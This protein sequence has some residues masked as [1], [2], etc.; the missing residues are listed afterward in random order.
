ML[1]TLPLASLVACDVPTEPPRWDQTWVVPVASIVIGA[2]DL[3]P[4]GVDVNQDTSAFVAETPE[5]SIHAT[6]AEV[7]TT[8]IIV[9]G[10]RTAKP[11][12]ADTLTTGTTLPAEVVSA[13][14]VGGAFDVV[15]GHNLNFDPLRPS[16][17]PAAP[18]G[19]MVFR[20]TSS[21]A[22]VAYD[23]ISGDDTAFPGG[24]TLTPDLTVRPVEVSNTID[25]EIYI[26]SPEGD[27]VTVQASDTAG[28]T[29]RPSTV[30]ISE[31]V[32]DAASI[33][34]DPVHATMDFS[35]VD[36]TAIDHVQ[37]GALLVA[38]ANPWDVSGTLDVTLQPPFPSIQRSLTLSPGT[39]QDRLDLGAGEIRA[40]LTA[41]E[42]GVRATGTVTSTGA[43]V[44]T[45]S[46]QLAVD[47]NLEL[48]VLIGDTEFR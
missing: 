41:G 2:S 38:V 22:V 43:V 26:Y 1:W 20:V 8:C 12:F 30:E 48:V 44:V 16:A 15:V 28:I 24:T 25:I 39:S 17:D 27:S 18:R 31:V 13:T 9:N 46:Q 23:S 32:L 36:A 7:C 34:V 5:A 29:L 45:P 33:T 42:V 14:L 3:L 10:L 11:E 47:S 40:I 19:Y 21:G 4:E 37:S 6:L 35:G